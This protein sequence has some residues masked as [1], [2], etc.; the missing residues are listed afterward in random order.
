MDANIHVLVSAWLL[1]VEASA[2]PPGDWTATLQVIT[3]VRIPKPT[4]SSLTEAPTSQHL[5]HQWQHVDGHHS[6]E[7]V[8]V[9][10]LA[11]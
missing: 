11:L 3:R 1:G 9:A 6:C 10:C 2:H 8:L 7:F 4:A 5:A